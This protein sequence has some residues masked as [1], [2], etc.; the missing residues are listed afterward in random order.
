MAHTTPMPRRRPL[1]LL[2]TLALAI[3]TTP[4]A[5]AAAPQAAPPTAKPPMTWDQSRSVYNRRIRP[6]QPVES[7]D[8]AGRVTALLREEP[9]DIVVT[10]VGDMIFN[11]QI[12]NL[13]EPHHQQLFRILQEADIAYGNLEFSMNSHPEA[14]RPFYNFRTDTEFV[15]E[16][17]AIGINMVSMANNHSLDFGPEGLKDCLAAL[18]RANMTYAGAGMTL[19]D[20][21]APGT[22]SVQSQKTKFALLSTMRYWTQKYRCTD[23]QSAVPGHDRPGG[24]PGREAGRL[25]RGRRGPAGEGRPGDGGRHRPGQAARRRS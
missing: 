9:G 8:W 5:R 7:I 11:E 4:A 23:P 22:T 1:A 18:E 6:P 12:S 3:A 17:A 20:A 10:A 13:P 2:L 25:D 21:R 16:L 24:D 14:Q 19:A 15:W